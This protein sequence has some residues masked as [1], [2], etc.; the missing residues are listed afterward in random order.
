MSHR[1]KNSGEIGACNHVVKFTADSP[2]QLAKLSKPF[3][4]KF[5]LGN[6]NFYQ[7]MNITGVLCSFGTAYHQFESIKIVVD[8]IDKMI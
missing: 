4:I 5:C 3:I 7:I 8:K 1:F 2:L 6:F